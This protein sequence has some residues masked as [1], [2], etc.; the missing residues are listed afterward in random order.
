MIPFRDRADAGRRLAERLITEVPDLAD[1]VVLALPRGGVP[2][3]YEVATRLG[4][5]LEVVVA[6]KV[7][8]PRQPE[9]GIGAIAEGGGEVTDAATMRVFGIDLDRFDELAEAERVELQRRVR[10]YRGDRA[11]PSLRDHDVVLVDDGLATGVTA[12]AAI[13]SV[14]RLG[15]RRLVLAAPVCA[16]DTVTR[17]T[18]MVDRV[19]CVEQPLRFVAVGQWYDDFDQ[20]SD[21]AVVD[22]LGRARGGDPHPRRRR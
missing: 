14:R 7:G 16:R 4:A 1:P 5:P 6:R 22:L 13:A 20:T 12:E 21:A 17:L 15:P 10:Q 8:A 11:L 3:A 18:P 2:V 9:L 19:V